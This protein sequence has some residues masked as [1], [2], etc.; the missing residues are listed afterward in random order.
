MISW[1][2][3]RR[4]RSS[5]NFK[6]LKG[7]RKIMK[8]LHEDGQSPGRNLKPGPSEYEAGMLTAP[9]RRSIDAISIADII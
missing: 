2:E 6:V 3:F 1:K 4:K 8:N 5:N 7:R 9:P